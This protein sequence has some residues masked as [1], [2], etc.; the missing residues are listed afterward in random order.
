LEDSEVTS[1]SY[2][3]NGQPGSGPRALV[4]LESEPTGANCS[5][6]GTVV[7]SG[8]DTNGNGTLE[9]SEITSTS[10]VCNGAPGT[11]GSGPRALVRLESE[12]AGA[13]CSQGGTAVRSGL[14]TNNNGTL[15]SSEV[16]STSYVC[17]GAQGQQGT[18]GTQALVRLDQEPAG[19]NCSQGGTAVRSGLDTNKNGTLEMSE[20]TQTQYICSVETAYATGWAASSPAA[21]ATGHVPEDLWFPA[22]RKASI[23]K[24]SP[25]SRLKVTVS[26]N[27]GIGLGVNGGTGYY[28]VR[29]NGRVAST[30][31]QQGMYNGNTSGWTHRYHFPFATVCLTDPLPVGLYEFEAWIYTNS[32]TGYA[33]A[34]T[35][36][37]LLFVEELPSTASY[38]FSMEGGMFETKS[39]TPQKASGRTV[40][41]T[42]QSGSTLLKLT[43]AD[44]MRVGYQQSVGEGTVRIRMDNTDTTC[45]HRQYD[46]QGTRG[47][48]QDPFVMTCIL[49]GVAAGSHT[50]DVWLNSDNGSEEA[51]LGWNRS[52]PLLLVEELSSQNLTYSNGSVTSGEISGAW[53]GV[54][55]RQVQHNVS[56]AGK[57]LRV[58]FSDTF[59][60]ASS[61]NGEWG[62][63]QLY[64]DGQP[65][66]CSNGQYAYNSG[67]VGQNHHHP[68][69]HVCLVRDLSPG[70]HTFSIWT[71]STCGSNYFGRIRGQNLLLVEE[72]P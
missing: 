47:D 17:N 5:Q 39:S 58:T 8:L 53:A 46:A 19:T 9:S 40:T 66:G 28:T 61:C 10:Y 38:G 37:A 57:T 69:N 48:F 4:R 25:T 15:D 31:C 20:V 45:A 18:P 27:L 21:Y 56:S 49:S 14:D 6:G 23:F 33:G 50:F 26:D 32:G 13:N 63:Y 29:M 62:L 36:E 54:T 3:C 43:L 7:R 34:S 11:P 35:S 65:T 44:T 42:K 59:R 22:G 30:K 64:V 60:S 70:A 12:P 52:Y 51:S 2:S 67:N 41:Y 72:L 68:I 1:T 16:T 55:G 71:T 24:T